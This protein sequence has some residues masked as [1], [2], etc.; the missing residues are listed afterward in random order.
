[1]L[2]TAISQGLTK[3]YTYGQVFAP[4][5]SRSDAQ[6]ETATVPPLPQPVVQA[7]VTALTLQ[8]MS[9]CD[10]GFGDFIRKKY[11]GQEFS[12]FGRKITFLKEHGELFDVE[13]AEKLR[14]VRN[15]LAHDSDVHATWEEWLD[16][17]EKVQKELRHLEILPKSAET[18]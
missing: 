6:D 14:L 16:T 8:L 17:Y 13:A 5:Y 12:T 2:N 11:H 1:M 7:A 3:A 10:D 4:N 15:E 18:S 9:L